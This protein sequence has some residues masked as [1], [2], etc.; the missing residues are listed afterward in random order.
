MD[1]H[2]NMDLKTLYDKL[3]L[4]LSKNNNKYQIIDSYFVYIELSSYQNFLNSYIE[5][6]TFCNSIYRYILN[7]SRILNLLTDKVF[8]VRIDSECIKGANYYSE[9]ILDFLN[10]QETLND[11]QQSIS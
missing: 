11:I 6:P 2:N 7:T 1:K 10:N 9:L 5:N 4:I 8:A 3:V